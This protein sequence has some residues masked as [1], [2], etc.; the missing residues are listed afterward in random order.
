MCMLLRIWGLSRR[1]VE[2][3]VLDGR[4]QM[5]MDQLGLL[6]QTGNAA[7]A[8]AAVLAGVVELE[9]TVLLEHVFPVV[10]AAVGHGL[11]LV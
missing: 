9:G 5:G 7:A 4:T 10:L 3:A 2:R 1:L 6:E 11:R 8:A